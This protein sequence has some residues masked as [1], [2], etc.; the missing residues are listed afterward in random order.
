MSTRAQR[1]RKNREAG[2]YVE[3]DLDALRKL[4]AAAIGV[5][6]AMSE[7]ADIIAEHEGPAG[8]AVIMSGVEKMFGLGW[9]IGGA[10]EVS[11]AAKRAALKQIQRAAMMGSVEKR[12]KWRI[13]ALTL[14]KAFV[15]KYPRYSQRG[16]ADY[17]AEQNIYGAPEQRQF[18]AVISK[19][20]KDG[21]L[22][23]PVKK[24]RLAGK[25]VQVSR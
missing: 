25:A 2:V 18:I 8:R 10:A 19:W 14:A 23:H 1:V 9:A 24:Y 16:L 5:L 11:P 20:W 3:S 15:A 21:D 13:A 22:T 4:V 7:V 12:T 6:D 17:L